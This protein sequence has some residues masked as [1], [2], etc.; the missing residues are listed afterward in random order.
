MACGLTQRDVARILGFANASRLS[1]WEHGMCL[2]SVKNILAL[3]CIYHVSVEFIYRELV[4][5]IRE[6]IQRRASQILAQ[7]ANAERPS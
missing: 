1:R 4:E 3:A 5:R 7:R 2:P 6:A